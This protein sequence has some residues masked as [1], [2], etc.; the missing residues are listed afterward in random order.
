PLDVDVSAIKVPSVKIKR[1]D[2]DLFSLK[3]GDLKANTKMM[4]GKYG[5]FYEGFLSNV[6][7]KMGTQDTAYP[8]EIMRFLSDADINAVYDDCKIK[9]HDLSDLEDKFHSVFQHYIYYFPTGKLP[10]PV[11][12]FTGFHD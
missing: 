11:A 6:I 8:R 2:T 1:F 9:F 10:V 12:A 3:N 7:C 5:D 4:I